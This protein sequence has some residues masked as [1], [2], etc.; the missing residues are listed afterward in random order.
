MKAIILRELGSPEKFEEADL[1]IRPPKSDEVLVQINAGS[2]NPIDCKIREGRIEGQC[3][4]FAGV[5]DML[6]DAPGIIGLLSLQ[7]ASI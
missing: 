6:A 3:C 4:N 5:S 1:P 7:V 2:I